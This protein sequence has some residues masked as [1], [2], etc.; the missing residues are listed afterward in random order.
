MFVY[1]TFTGWAPLGG[2]SAASMINSASVWKQILYGFQS[3]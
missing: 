3:Y 2:R 1:D